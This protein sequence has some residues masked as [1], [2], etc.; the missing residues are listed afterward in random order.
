MTTVGELS[1]VQTKYKWVIDNFC[2]G[3]M[4]TGQS[5]RSPKFSTNYGAETINWYISVYPKGD[6]DSSKDWIS[7]YLT[8][9]STTNFKAAVTFKI[10]YSQNKV[11]ESSVSSNALFSKNDVWGFEQFMSR[12]CIMDPDYD[13]LTDGRLT[14]VCE[15]TVNANKEIDEEEEENEKTKALQTLPMLRDRLTK[16]K[17]RLEAKDEALAQNSLRLKELDELEQLLIDETN[18]S[19]VELSVEG[20]TI[21]AHRCILAKKSPVFAAMFQAE[22][23]EKSENKVEIQDMKYSVFAELLRYVYS[24]KVTGIETMAVELLA[25]AGRYSIDGLKTMCEKTICSSLSVDNAVESFG[26]AE[27]HHLDELRRRT[28]HFIVAHANEIVGRPE[29]QLIGLDVTREILRAVVENKKK[30][31][32]VAVL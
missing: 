23:K 16:L 21:R 19:D 17:G 12:Q 30:P 20:K 13:I 6:E 14:I 8:S 5:L 9:I 1:L 22:M 26:L 24:C 15:L 2:T 11:V 25:A 29:F 18:Y 3:C 7:V 10:L 31:Q 27:R 28:F 4:K 32:A